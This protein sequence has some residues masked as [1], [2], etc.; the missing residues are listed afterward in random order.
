MIEADKGRIQPVLL[1]GWRGAE[2]FRG[3]VARGD[4]I[5]PCF[6]VRAPLQAV[7]GAIQQRFGFAE[8]LRRR[9]LRRRRRAPR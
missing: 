2:R 5:A 9:L 6:A 7:L 4:G 1:P 8:L 3:L